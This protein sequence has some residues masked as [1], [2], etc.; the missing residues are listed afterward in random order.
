M[1]TPTIL[2]ASGR[3]FDFTA[4]EPFEFKIEDIAHALSRLCRFGG[5]TKKFY[6]VAQHAVHVSY[7]VPESLEMEGLLHDA[8][9][10]FVGDMVR[11]L[12]AL[13]PEFKAIEDRIYAAIAEQY[14][15]PSQMSSEVKRA[16]LVLLATEQRDLM[17]PH[18]DNWACLSGIRPLSQKIEPMTP[19]TAYTWFI[20]RYNAIGL[21]R[22]RRDLV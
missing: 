10:A 2:T 13:M 9:E 19:E 22:V 15:I 6:S 11:P 5:H 3:Y 4:P 18:D 8:A 20:G 14:R 7:I 12:K 16:D 1:S 17:P 21:N